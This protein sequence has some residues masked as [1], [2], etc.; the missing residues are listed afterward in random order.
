MN[1]I[2]FHLFNKEYLCQCNRHYSIC[3][4]K[5]TDEEIYDKFMLYSNIAI[6]HYCAYPKET[7]DVVNIQLFNK[8]I[9]YS[10]QE[11]NNFLKKYLYDLITLKKKFHIPVGDVLWN[12]SNIY[13]VL[14]ETNKS[15]VISINEKIYAFIDDDYFYCYW[16]YYKECICRFFTF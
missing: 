16:E 10:L 7:N 4:N 8:S 13:D 9:L 11:L 3:E 2:F 5:L 14:D 6:V 15:L 1:K 12:H